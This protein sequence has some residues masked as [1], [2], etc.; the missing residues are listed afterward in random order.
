[1]CRKRLRAPIAAGLKIHAVEVEDMLSFYSFESN[2][3]R[4][5]SHPPV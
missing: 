3:A 5:L 4:P 2:A 1:M